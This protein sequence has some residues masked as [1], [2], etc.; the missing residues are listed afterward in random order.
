MKIDIRSEL[1]EAHVSTVHK[2]LLFYDLTRLS[3]VNN[4]PERILLHFFR[5]ARTTQK[6]VWREIESLC[7][8]TRKLKSDSNLICLVLAL[9]T[10]KQNT[11]FDANILVEHECGFIVGIGPI[12]S[13]SAPLLEN[14]VVHF[15]GI[16]E[17]LMA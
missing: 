16:D 17:K 1:F 6:I 8:L 4:R 10:S 13:A 5:S 14:N 9:F 3:T 12:M 7:P 2:A 15:K 11:N